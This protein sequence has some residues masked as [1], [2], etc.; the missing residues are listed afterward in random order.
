MKSST[1]Q[2][3]YSVLRQATHEFS[4]LGKKFARALM[5]TPLPKILLVCVALTLLIT[6]IPLALTL[7]A[8]F[9]LLKLLLVLLALAVQKNRRDPSELTYTRPKKNRNR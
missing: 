1:S 7:F 4:Y 6:L 8:V 5:R 9:V 2:Y 3:L